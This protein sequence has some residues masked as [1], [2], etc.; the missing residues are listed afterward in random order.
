MEK[1]YL[2]RVCGK[3]FVAKEEERE[4][5]WHERS[6]GYYYHMTCWNEYIKQDF[7]VNNKDY[8]DLVFYLINNE[9]HQEYNYYQIS[10]QFDKMIKDGKTGKGIY[11]TCYWYFIV[12]KKEYKPEF[13]I[14][15]IPYVYDQSVEYWTEQESR[16]RGI[17]NEIAKLAAIEKGAG[18]TIGAKRT[19]RKRKITEEPEL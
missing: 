15:I 11:F 7:A 18:R 4:I 17:M 3:R 8:K 5:T 10:T 12:C 19:N 13:G 16:K 2:C 1:T 6:K 9:L 14:G